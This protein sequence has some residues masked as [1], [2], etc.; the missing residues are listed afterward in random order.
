MLVH[1]GVLPASVNFKHKHLNKVKR[2]V[3]GEK[4]GSCVVHGISVLVCMYRM[5]SDLVVVPF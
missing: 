3:V 5:H 4:V 1:F 2:F